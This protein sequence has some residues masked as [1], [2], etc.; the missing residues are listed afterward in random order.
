MKGNKFLAAVLAAS[1]AFSAV[2]ATTLSVFAATVDTTAATADNAATVSAALKTAADN[3]EQTAVANDTAAGAA[4]TGLKN[5]LENAV[6]T[7]PSASGY[8]V[9]ATADSVSPYSGGYDAA[10]NK[11]KYSVVVT[12]GGGGD[13]AKIAGTYVVE[14]TV[15]VKQD[16]LDTAVSKLVKGLEFSYDATKDEDT[17]TTAAAKQV[18]DALNED[19]TLNVVKVTSKATYTKPSFSSGA[20]TKAKYTFAFDNISASG[21]KYDSLKPANVDVDIES[22]A[23]KVLDAAETIVKA[24]D[25][26]NGGADPTTSADEITAAIKTAFE[27]ATDSESNTAKTDYT[28]IDVSTALDATN[29]DTT[30]LKGTITLKLGDSTRTIKFTRTISKDAIATSIVNALKKSASDKTYY[31]AL[32]KEIGYNLTT[33][34]SANLATGADKDA[35]AEAVKKVADQYLK[36]KDI[37]GDPSAVVDVSVYEFDKTTGAGF[38]RGTIAVNRNGVTG[39]AAVFGLNVAYNTTTNKFEIATGVSLDSDIL[40]KADNQKL[41]EQAKAL[42][43]AVKKNADLKIKNTV[44]TRM[45]PTESQ[46]VAGVK[47]KADPSVTGVTYKLEANSTDDKKVIPGS[48]A[49]DA[50]KVKSYTAPT[51]EADGT[52]VVTVTYSILKDGAT[53]GST[54]ASDYVTSAHDI[55]LTFK[56]LS[57]RTTTKLSFDKE[58]VALYYGSKSGNADVKDDDGNSLPIQLDLLDVIKSNGNSKLVWTSSD[59]SVVTVDENGKITSAGIGE[60]TITVAVEGNSDVKATIKV[61]VSTGSKFKDVQNAYAYYYDAVN[62]FTSRDYDGSYA[63]KGVKVVAGV[64][65]DEFGVS[66]PVTRAQFVTFLYR[67]AGEPNIAATSKFSDVASDAYYAKAVAWAVKNNITAGK[68]DT[69]FAPNDTVTRAE[70]VTFLYRFEGEPNYTSSIDTKFDDV[71]EGSYYYD[72]VQWAAQNN[73]TAGKTNTTFAP[74]DNC[75]RAEGITF[76]YRTVTL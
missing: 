52:A 49:D 15:D 69:H 5:T 14:G 72:A 25:A 7:L 18:Q 74:K 2:P 30:K 39:D 23:D 31:N 19:D 35:L 57:A 54:K 62:Y 70:A 40:Q 17:N 12:A 10:T 66:A 47:D 44:N 63:P 26:Y 68:D 34:D 16:D 8:T 59:D 58:K 42:D 65:D 36:D 28:K 33:D 51:S 37:A 55:T 1:M 20:E 38:A 45:A 27:D 71:K 22:N 32:K 53:A 64:S 9:T 61:T 48:T 21:N 13:T 56:K 4:V 3:F 6:K 50:V 11:Y 76:I 73:V 46:I 24:N 43:D 41:A 67:A 29:T 60:A 75:N